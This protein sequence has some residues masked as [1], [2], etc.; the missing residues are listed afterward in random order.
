MRRPILAISA[1]EIRDPDLIL[2]ADFIAAHRVYG[3]TGDGKT[4]FGR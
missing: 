2:G 4:E 3:A 1:L